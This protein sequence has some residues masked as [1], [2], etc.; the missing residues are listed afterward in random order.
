MDDRENIE[1]LENVNDSNSC[2]TGF[3][4]HGENLYSLSGSDNYFISKYDLQNT[5]KQ[6]HSWNFDDPDADVWGSKIAITQNQLVVADIAHSRLRIYSL[7]GKL[8]KHVGCPKF[9]KYSWICIC[10]SPSN[11][12]VIIVSDYDI[13]PV[14]A[15]N[16]TTEAVLWTNSDIINPQGIVSYGS[17]HVLV[18]KTDSNTQLWILN[19]NTGQP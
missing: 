19:A 1:I 12:D 10:V 14:F 15:V 6:L 13:S 3:C 18:T 5:I 4:V 2:F 11:P 16:L 17:E 7:T 8:I 9:K